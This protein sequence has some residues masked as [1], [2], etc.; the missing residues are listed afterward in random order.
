MVNEECVSQLD[1]LSEFLMQLQP[2]DYNE[3]S[4]IF[5]TASVGQHV[6]HI[7]ELFSC[8][9]D[10]YD[11]GKINYDRRNRSILLETDP[12]YAILSISKIQSKLHLPDKELVLE[13]CEGKGAKKM[14]TSYFRELWYNLEHCIH[15]QALIR[16]ACKSIPYI[17]LKESFG[18]AKATLNYRA[19]LTDNN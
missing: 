9:I 14:K 19:S 2:E 4:P 6:R 3:V 8:L 1:E 13:A 16:L 5:Q 12:A 7:I 11:S 18:V 10:Q 15:H 17:Q